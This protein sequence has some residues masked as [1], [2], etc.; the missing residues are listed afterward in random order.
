MRVYTMTKGEEV[1]ASTKLQDLADR[2][3]KTSNALRVEFSRANKDVIVLQGW[4]ISRTELLRQTR[5]NNNFNQ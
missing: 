1:T 3:K 5:P 4:T 2:I